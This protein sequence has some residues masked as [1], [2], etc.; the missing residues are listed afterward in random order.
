M[1]G[2]YIYKLQRNFDLRWIDLDESLCWNDKLDLI[3]LWIRISESHQVHSM[4]L[5]K[6]IEASHKLSCILVLF[7]APYFAAGKVFQF[8]TFEI[9]LEYSN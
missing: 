6:D 4:I 8:E 3:F 9:L 7:E 5:D 2:L 1:L